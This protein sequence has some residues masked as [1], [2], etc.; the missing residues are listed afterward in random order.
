MAVVQRTIRPY[1]TRKR[2]ME[3]SKR[4]MESDKAKLNWR[5]V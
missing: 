5:Q 1:S 4:K 2:V 3:E